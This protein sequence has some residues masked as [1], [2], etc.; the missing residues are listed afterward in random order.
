MISKRQQD[1]LA[2]DGIVGDLNL[3]TS[4]DFDNYCV[5]GTF[6]LA[7]GYPS[8]KIIHSLHSDF[9]SSRFGRFRPSHITCP[10]SAKTSAATTASLTAATSGYLHRGLPSDASHPRETEARGKT[11][12]PTDP[13]SKRE[14]VRKVFVLL[15][16]R[17]D[18]VGEAKIKRL[19]PVRGREGGL[20]CAGSSS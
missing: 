19:Q 16:G 9:A 18:W 20:R 5:N 10:P 14:S 13:G 6:Y 11:P 15:R 3:M 4:Q 1:A 2:L 7:R 17:C 8:N 12:R